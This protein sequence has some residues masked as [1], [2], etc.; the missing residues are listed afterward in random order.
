MGAKGWPAPGR[1]FLASTNISCTLVSAYCIRR[2]CPCGRDSLYFRDLAVVGAPLDV[3]AQIV[4]LMDATDAMTSQTIEARHSYQAE[5]IVINNSQPNLLMR[6]LADGCLSVD[7]QCFLRNFVRTTPSGPGVSA[8]YSPHT[9]CLEKS[10]SMLTQGVSSNRAASWR[11]G[12]MECAGS[13]DMTSGEHGPQALPSVDEGQPLAGAIGMRSAEFGHVV[14]DGNEE[15]HSV[16][17]LETLEE[18]LEG[19]P[20][21]ALLVSRISMLL[22]LYLIEHGQHV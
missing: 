14:V 22:T 21:V 6:R 9:P 12:S 7:Y 17:F 18:V 13:G 20:L 10:H 5:D 3:N 19:T 11:M 15:G 8:M 1:V 4:A 2:I 16:T